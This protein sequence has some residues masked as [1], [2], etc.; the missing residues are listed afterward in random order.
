MTTIT[1]LDSAINHIA[2]MLGLDTNGAVWV[3][4][5]SDC[6]E[7]NEDRFDDYDFLGD[8]CVGMIPSEFVK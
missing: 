2:D 3:Y 5:N 1:N 4:A 8:E 7:W 6:P